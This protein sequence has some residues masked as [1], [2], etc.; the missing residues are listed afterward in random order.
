MIQMIFHVF[1]VTFLVFVICKPITYLRIGNAD[2]LEHR[3]M[4]GNFLVY[5]AIRLNFVVL[6]P[7]KLL[8][9]VTVKTIYL[10][11]FTVL[12]KCRSF[13]TNTI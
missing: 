9:L 3:E 13:L 10:Y 8:V 2:Q 6:W 12:R 5:E 1:I 11:L 7:R 4:S